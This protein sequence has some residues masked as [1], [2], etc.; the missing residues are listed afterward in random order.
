MQVCYNAIHE[1]ECFTAIPQHLFGGFLQLY[2][3]H[4]LSIEEVDDALG[5]AG[6]SLGVCHHHDGSALLIELGEELHHF[7]TIFGVEVSCRLVGE[8]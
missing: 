2:F 8:D 6:V 7:E 1:I 3:R 4:H 5:I